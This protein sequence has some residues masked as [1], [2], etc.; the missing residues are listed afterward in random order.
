MPTQ[1]PAKSYSSPLYMPGISAVS[2][3][4]REHPDRMQP[5]PIP[6]ITEVAISVFREPVA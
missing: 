1:K 6:E 3:P 5:S 2:P 4:I